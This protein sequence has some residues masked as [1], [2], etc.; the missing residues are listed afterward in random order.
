M[1]NIF[2]LIAADL[3]TK[4]RRKAKRKAKEKRNNHLTWTPERNK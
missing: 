2:N 3:T 1:S 4:V